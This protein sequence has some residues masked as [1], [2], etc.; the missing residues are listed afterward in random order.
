MIINLNRPEELKKRMMSQG[1]SSEEADAAV[2]RFRS[3]AKLLFAEGFDDN[4]EKNES[5]DKN[6]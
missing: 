2:E 1:M 5:E 3:A 6:G 4:D